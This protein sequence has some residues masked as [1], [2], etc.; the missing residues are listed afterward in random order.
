MIPR[1]YDG[2]ERT[3]TVQATGDFDSPVT[4]IEDTP[5]NSLALEVAKELHRATTLFGSITNPHEGLGIIREEYI[6]FENEVF[7]YN[8]NKNRDTRPKMREELIQLAAMCLRTIHDV[9]DQ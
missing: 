7:R 9:I 5:V 8:P 1:S 2:I 4:M 6:E 3:E